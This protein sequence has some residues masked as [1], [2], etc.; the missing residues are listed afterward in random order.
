MPAFFVLLNSSKVH[1]HEAPMHFA[2]GGFAV[3][4]TSTEP[5]IEPGI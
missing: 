3:Y 5:G 2:A 1:C 4:S